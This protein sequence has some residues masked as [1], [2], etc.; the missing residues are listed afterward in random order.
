MNKF[1]HLKD[2]FYKL[3]A[4]SP[5]QAA[6]VL[7]RIKEQA[8]KLITHSKDSIKYSFRNK[9][10]FILLII[11]M[12]TLTTS[13]LSSDLTWYPFLQNLGFQEYWFGYLISASFVSGI[14]I[15]HFTKPLVKKI[16]NYNKYLMLCLIAQLILLFIVGFIASLIFAVIIFLIFISTYDFYHPVRTTFFQQLVPGKMRAT[17]DSFRNMTYEIVGII[18]MPLAGF[19]ADKISPQYTISIG[20]FFLIPA[21]YLYTKIKVKGKVK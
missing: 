17:I 2:R 3:I 14:I 6:A 12:I 8:K 20:S 4:L 19:L 11:G 13:I 5:Q 1:S 9:P 7:I 15:P 16:G 10:L 21:I 18:M